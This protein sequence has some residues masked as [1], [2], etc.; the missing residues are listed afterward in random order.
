[1]KTFRHRFTVKAP[2][3]AVTAFH[4]DTS[5]LHNLMPPPLQL[6]FHRLDPMAEG[7]VA[8]FSM[9]LGPFKV[10]WTAVHTNVTQEGFT[11]TQ[12]RGPFKSWQHRH[13]FRALDAQTT[14]VIDE[15]E[16]QPAGLLSWLMWLTLPILFVYRS[17]QT[18]RLSPK[19][20]V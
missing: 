6:K 10:H 15:V 3:T 14:E 4:S 5:A 9:G 18:R 20:V 1:M 2:L 8:D 13:T 7:A 16:A 19:M 12:Q 11:D 17:W